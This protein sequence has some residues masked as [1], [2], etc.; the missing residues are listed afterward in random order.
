MSDKLV[1]IMYDVVGDIECIIDQIE[2]S[3]GKLPDKK[4]VRSNAGSELPQVKGKLVTAIYQ[5]L[6]LSEYATLPLD[7]YEVFR[8]DRP[9][10]TPMPR[11]D[12]RPENMFNV[13]DHVVVNNYRGRTRTISIVYWTE[14]DPEYEHQQPPHYHYITTY[15][16]SDI[17]DESQLKLA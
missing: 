14:D 13:G 10:G 5:D 8:A 6:L 7:F 16:N 15:D 9:E 4:I 12:G 2:A 3:E 1:Y 17:F 11:P